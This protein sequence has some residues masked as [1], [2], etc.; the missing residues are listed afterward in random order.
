MYVER[1]RNAAETAQAM[2]MDS[3]T[4]QVRLGITGF[5]IDGRARDKDGYPVETT[6]TIGYNTV[7]YGLLDPLP[8]ALRI[9]RRRLK[10]QM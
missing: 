10:E 4:Y 8:A 7:I 9:V 1:L 5:V 3:E 2:S 6:T